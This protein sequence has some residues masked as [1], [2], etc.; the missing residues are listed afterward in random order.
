VSY[1]V[2]DAAFLAC[3]RPSDLPAEVRHKI[4]GAYV[5]RLAELSRL[6]TTCPSTNFLRDQ[7][8]P[9]ALHE[10]G[11]YPFRTS[12]TEA[13]TICA[14]EFD[15]QV[16]DV[17]RLAHFLLERSDLIEDLGD[18]RDVAVE[19]CSIT[20]KLKNDQAPRLYAQLSRMLALIALGRENLGLGSENMLLATSLSSEGQE[21]LAFRIGVSLAERHDGSI[22]EPENPI[23][24]TLPIHSDANSYLRAINPSVLIQQASADAI[25]DS[26]IA[27]AVRDDADPIARAMLLSKMIIIGQNFLGTASHLGFLHESIKIQRLLRACADV[28][29][30][31]NLTKSHHLRSGPG[32]D[33]P[34]RTRGNFTAWRHDLDDEFHLHY[35]RN[36][37]I[38]EFANVVVHNDF[39]ITY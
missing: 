15:I 2:I 30:R 39:D 26:C 21:E 29:L 18:F 10:I 37:E 3:P 28:L 25:I 13:L 19:N 11:C 33:D 14:D 24:I 23:D 20:P 17:N 6:R 34:Q 8:L 9:M 4:V 32:G 31:R 1:L 7:Q 27:F 38:I 36:G 12:L 16:E 5:S 35:W 22:V